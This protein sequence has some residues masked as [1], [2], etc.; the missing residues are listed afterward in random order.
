MV[1]RIILVGM[2][3]VGKTTVGS[4][5]AER[6]GW[7]YLDSDAQVMADSGRTVPELF[8]ER[9]EAAFR[10][11]ESRVLAAALASD[12]PVVVSA[13]GGVILSAANRRLLTESGIVVWMRAHPSVLA[14]RVGT[15]AGRPLLDSDPSAVLSGLDGER[16]ELYASVAAVTVDVDDLTPQ[17][18][19]DRVLTDQAV[20]DAGIGPTSRR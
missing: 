16:R 17:Q 4:R 15:G 14:R 20:L 6:L 19:V 10:A 7:A 8:A 2:M 13:A 12:E 9:G 18:V 1:D 5:L 3:G 11:A